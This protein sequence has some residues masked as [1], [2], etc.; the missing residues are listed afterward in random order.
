[1]IEGEVA[2][3]GKSQIAKSGVVAIVPPNSHPA[4]S[5]LTNGRL[6]VVDHPAR[7]DFE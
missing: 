3:D 1:V 7:P 4:V 2:I 6:I 5:A